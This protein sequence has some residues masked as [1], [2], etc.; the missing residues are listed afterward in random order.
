MDSNP[1]VAYKVKESG[2]KAKDSQASIAFGFELVFKV[3]QNKRIWKYNRQ[4]CKD[5]PLAEQHEELL[6][7]QTHRVLNELSLNQGAMSTGATSQSQTKKARF[8][9]ACRSPKSE[10]FVLGS[11]SF[12]EKPGSQGVDTCRF[13]NR[14]GIGMGDWDVWISYSNEQ[15]LLKKRAKTLVT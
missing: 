12:V 14:N 5:W 3:N 1:A 7:C 8:F 15:G 6:E 13:Q 9:T 4:L 11:P 10:K 2:F